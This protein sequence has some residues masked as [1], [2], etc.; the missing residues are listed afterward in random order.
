VDA[1]HRAAAYKA[2][3]DVLVRATH[4]HLCHAPVTIK[5]AASRAD[6]DVK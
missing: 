4:G 6:T 5:C 1:L 2:P 3:R